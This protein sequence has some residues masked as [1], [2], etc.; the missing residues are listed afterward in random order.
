[1][2]LGAE[3]RSSYFMLAAH[4]AAMLRIAGNPAT[5]SISAIVVTYACNRLSYAETVAR[6]T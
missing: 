2:E 6:P 5:Q 1:M 4:I 3:S